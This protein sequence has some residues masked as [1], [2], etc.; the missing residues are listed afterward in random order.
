MTKKNK[1]QFYPSALTIT[2]CDSGGGSGIAA[3]LRT[4]NAFGVFGTCAVTAAAAQNPA[5]V[6]RTDRLEADSV[7]A[8]IDAVTEKIAVDFCKTGMLFS[9]GII[10]AVAAAVEKYRF[11]LVCDPV[12][13]TS[14]NNKVLKSDAVETL[15]DKLLPLAAWI[16]PGIAEAE[17]LAGVRISSPDDMFEAAKILSERFSASVLLKGGTADDNISVD[18][19]ARSGKLFTLTAPALQLPQFTAHGADDTLSAALTA[20]LALDMPWKQAVCGSRAFVYGSLE[21]CVELGRNLQ[22]MYPPTEDFSQLVKLTPVD[23]Q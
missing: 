1:N 7:T 6:R 3:D 21:Q 17:V 11:T 2:G 15:V 12:M 5:A 19:V 10:E 13:V 8:Q 23:S 20:M 14:G 18:I 4:F 16:T 22:G 9:S